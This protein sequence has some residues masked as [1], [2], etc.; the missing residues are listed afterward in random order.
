MIS[1]VTGAAG[2]IGSNLV[3]HLLEHGHQ[4]VCIDNESA[5]D[6]ID[7]LSNRYTGKPYRRNPGVSWNEANIK[8]REIW[9]VNPAKVISMVRPQAKSDPE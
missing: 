5:N 8:S 9:E 4:V 6:H 3:D 1:L 7:Y 2:F